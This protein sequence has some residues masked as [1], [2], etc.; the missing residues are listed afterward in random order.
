NFNTRFKSGILSNLLIGKKKTIYEDFKS[1]PWIW[2]CVLSLCRYRS[3]LQ[4]CSF[5]CQFQGL[6]HIIKIN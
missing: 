4:T 5:E 1:P 6:L 2:M 3:F